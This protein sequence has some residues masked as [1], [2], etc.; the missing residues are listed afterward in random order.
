[1]YSSGF[2]LIINTAW[3]MLNTVIIPAGSFG[4]HGNITFIN[5][6]VLGLGG[7]TLARFV[8]FCLGG[9]F[10]EFTDKHFKESRKEIYEEV[11]KK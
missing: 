3:S 6:L 2:Q 11:N 7:I 8:R 9:N 10:S 5:I 4:S 1:M